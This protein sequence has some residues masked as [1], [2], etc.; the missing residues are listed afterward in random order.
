[1]RSTR[2]LAKLSEVAT[3][4]LERLK[5]ISNAALAV[6]TSRNDRDKRLGFVILETQNLWSNFVR[7]YLLSLL[8]SPRRANGKR[9]ALGNLAVNTPGDLLHIAAKATKGPLAP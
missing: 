3:Y 6:A 9:V 7:S 4:R 1:M 2:S 5:T 8:S